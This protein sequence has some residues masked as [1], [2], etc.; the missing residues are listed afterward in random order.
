MRGFLVDP[1]E[2]D[3]ELAMLRARG[4]KLIGLSERHWQVIHFLR[5]WYAE[6]GVVPTVCQTCRAQGTD[7]DRL[8]ELFPDGYHRGA[9]KLAG[10]RVV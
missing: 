2:W 6:H 1:E 3:P 7:L 10:L 4:M 8:E 9:V 5:S